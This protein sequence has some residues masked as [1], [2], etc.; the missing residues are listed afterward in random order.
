MNWFNEL[1]IGS[2]VL[3]GFVLMA[4]ITG[5]IGLIG[6]MNINAINKADR[7]M[8]TLMTL[9]LGQLYTVSADFQ[10]IQ[11]TMQDLIEAKSPLEKQRHLDTMKGVRVQFVDAVNAYSESIRTKNGEKLFADLIKARE[12]YVPL[13]NRMIELAM[14]GKKNEA[15]FLMRGEAKVAGA[16][17][18]AAIAVLVKNK[19]TR[20]TEAF[21][22]NT[23]VA[24]RANNAM[25]VT[26]ILGA[27]FAL[28][29]AFFINRNIGNI[30]KELLNEIARLS[31]AAVNGKLDTRGD[32][33]KINLEFKG[34]VQGFNNTLDSVIGPLNVAAEYV[35]RISKGDMPPRIADNYK[36]DFNEIKN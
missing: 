8:H 15:L 22:A 2:K 17:E 27:L 31:E 5:F 11:T 25:V 34:I 23:A 18:E 28:G 29:F 6:V 33:S 3:G 21:E 26:M 12:I 14:A 32:V 19:L 7:E 9:P 24:H 36:G 13:L 30:L 1:K 4:L 35:D 16:A 20:S 10:K